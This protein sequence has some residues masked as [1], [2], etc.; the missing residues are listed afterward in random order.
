MHY[1]YIHTY[2]H[3]YI[4]SFSSSSKTHSKSDNRLIGAFNA[5]SNLTGVLT[6]TIAVSCLL[7][8]YGALAMWDYAS[9]G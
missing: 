9:A 1:T 8:K 2:I 5:G 6:D 3:T 4:Y 7:H